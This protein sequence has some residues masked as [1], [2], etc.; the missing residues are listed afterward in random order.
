MKK[1]LAFIMALSMMSV[2][3]VGCTQN[4]TTSTAAP[5]QSEQAKSEAPKADPAANYPEKNIQLIVP[6]SAGGG[7]DALSRLLAAALEKELGKPVIVVNKGGSMGQIGLTDLAKAK[8]DGYT[9]GV[10][11]NSDHAIV[12][13]SSKNLEYS[14]DSF[15]LIAGINTTSS[16]L[17][18]SKESGL[19]TLA[20]VIDYAKA[21]PKKLTVAV[22]GPAF[23]MYVKQIE[24]ILGVEFT[25]LTYDGAGDS[26]NAVMGGHADLAMAD[27]KFHSQTTPK[28][29]VSLVSF[30]D[31]APDVL[32]GK[33]PTMLELGFDYT[34]DLYRM[35]GAPAGTPKEI[36]AK[37]EATIKKV[38]EEPDFQEKMK[39]INEIYQWRSTEDINKT[40]KKDFDEIKALLDANPG[41]LG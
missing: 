32:E 27:K 21:N 39:N 31:K 36:L 5:A 23:I 25:M 3:F 8:P 12:L 24:K 6:Y 2:M 4:K 14:Y 41:M 37:L 18:A 40:A 10:L 33:V 1:F 11:T 16:I 29:C 20:E 38:S 28:G 30:A 17:I 9:L 7:T 13:S 22:S 19:K 26:I 34:A 15:E 35:I